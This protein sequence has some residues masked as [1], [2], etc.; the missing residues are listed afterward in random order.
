MDN[1]N[2]TNDTVKDNKT[3]K[4]KVNDVLST[5]YIIKDKVKDKLYKLTTTFMTKHNC[6]IKYIQLSK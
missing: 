4:E 5:N 1:I 3:T 2:S 6:F